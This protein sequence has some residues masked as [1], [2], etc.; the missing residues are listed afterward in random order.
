MALVFRGRG[1][2]LQPD[3]CLQCHCFLR[4]LIGGWKE[5]CNTI[6]GI[7]CNVFLT[8]RLGTIRHYLYFLFQRMSLA[9]A[10]CCT[11]EGRNRIGASC[12][13]PI[14][15]SLGKYGSG[16]R[17]QTEF[18]RKWLRRQYCSSNTVPTC[19]CLPIVIRKRYMSCLCHDTACAS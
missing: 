11:N 8:V 5:H 15:I 13:N 9:H 6:L 1:F 18:F 2:L 7:S 10:I 19:Y 4:H 14:T 3:Y 16:S 17:K 12:S